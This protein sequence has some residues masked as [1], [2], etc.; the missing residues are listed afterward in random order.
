[1][2]E[3]FYDSL[4]L[5][6]ILEMLSKECSN[7][8]TK[9]MA[10]G[11]KPCSDLYTVKKE[12]GKTAEALELSV[13]YGTPNFYNI[14]DVSTYIKRAEAGGVLSLGELI[15]IR[16]LLAQTYELHHWYE[17]CENKDTSLSYLFEMLYPNKYLQQRLETAIIDETKLSDDASAELRS[18]RQK[19]TRSGLK[20]RE[21]LDKMIKSPSTQKYLQESIVTMRDGRFVLPVKTEFK[22]NVS[23]L[24]HDTSATGST[25][26]IEP[27][28]V[29]EANN[30]IRILQGQEQD[31][32]HRIIAEFSM[33]CAEMKDQLISNYNAVTELNLYFAKANLGAKMRAMLPE[34]SNDGVIVLNKA[35][36]PLIDPKKVV[37][38]NFSIGTDYHSLI[39]TGPNTGGKT[40]WVCSRL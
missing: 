36:H 14:N 8:K 23:G 33:E 7:E 3:R 21:T 10:L 1:M 13:R 19:I 12:T 26:F 16:R 18:I 9:K 2:D 37:P 6:K 40:L 32:I 31:E 20:I 28:S 24:V 17:Q 39:I 15:Q 30:D 25:L 38:I 35:R 4:E 27:M 5:N 29:V 22:G 11:I 34:I